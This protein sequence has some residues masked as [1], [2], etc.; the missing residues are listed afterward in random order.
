M[1]LQTIA[2]IF[3]AASIMVSCNKEADKKE[4]A[5]TP[6]TPFEYVAEQFADIKVL[7]YQIPGWENL[8]LK[9]QELVYYLT[10]AG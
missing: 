2:G 5:K 1:K 10:Q 7:R 4:E 9:E 3:I 6:E 8:T